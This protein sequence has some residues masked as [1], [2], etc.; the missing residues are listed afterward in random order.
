MFAIDHDSSLWKNLSNRRNT[1][2]F[3]GNLEKMEVA[4]D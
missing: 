1:I 3:L 4:K 2:G